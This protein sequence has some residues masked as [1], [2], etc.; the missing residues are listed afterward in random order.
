MQLHISMKKEKNPE[1][2][3]TTNSQV[4]TKCTANERA[5]TIQFLEQRRKKI[6]GKLNK[7]RIS[8]D[9]ERQ[10]YFLKF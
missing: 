3:F 8:K 4:N 6:F 10:N 5:K 1:S 9:N 2:D 7:V